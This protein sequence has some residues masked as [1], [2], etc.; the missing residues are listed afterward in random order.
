MTFRDYNITEFKDDSGNKKELRSNKRYY[1]SSKIRYLLKTQGYSKID[2]YGVKLCFPQ[3]NKL[4]AEDF[5]M[6]IITE[7]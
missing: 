6:L 1:L 2:I 4:T 3:N 5:E 7:K